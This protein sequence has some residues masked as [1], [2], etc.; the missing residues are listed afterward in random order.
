MKAKR[1]WRREDIWAGWRAHLE[2]QRASGQTQAAYCDARG[3]DPRYFS[4]WKGKL[5]GEKRSVG[6][7]S[8]PLRLVPLLVKNSSCGSA[9][10]EPLSIQLSLRNGL[11]V[12]LSLPS[13]VSLRSVLAELAQAPC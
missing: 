4:V 13:T 12:S 5:A 6:K 11:S 7:A 1:S 10:P 8:A 9:S 3:L 2:A